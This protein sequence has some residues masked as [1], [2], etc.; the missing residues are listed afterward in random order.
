[1]PNKHYSY[2]LLSACNV[3]GFMVGSCK[4]LNH[5]DAALGQTTTNSDAFASWLD[6]HLL[7]ALVPGQTTVVMDGCSIHHQNYVRDRLQAHR[8]ELVILPPYSPD[9]NVRARAAPRRPAPAAAPV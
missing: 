4:L 7:P 3:D 8:I 5:A 1:M 9:F 6:T 2:S